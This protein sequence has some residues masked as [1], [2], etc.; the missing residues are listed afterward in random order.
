MQAE[1][2]ILAWDLVRWMH[3]KKLPNMAWET[4][5]YNKWTEWESDKSYRQCHEERT[6]F[7]DA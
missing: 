3:S 2:Q 4:A 7:T 1:D 5:E 6:D